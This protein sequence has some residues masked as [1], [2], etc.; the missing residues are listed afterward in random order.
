MD[1]GQG[2]TKTEHAEQLAEAVRIACIEAALAGYED[3]AASGLCHE[4]AWE[5]AISAL[6]QLDI[7]AIIQASFGDQNSNR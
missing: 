6:Q 2:Q 4:G 1:T 7:T 5:A 3:A